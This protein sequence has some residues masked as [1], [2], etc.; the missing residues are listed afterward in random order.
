M[1]STC[2]GRRAGSSNRL[3][4]RASWFRSQSGSASVELVVLVVPIM[5]LALFTVLV[6]RVASVRQEV[7]SAARDAARAA[8]V[9]QHPTA[10]LE[11]AERVA[12][13]ALA[14]RGVSCQTLTVREK[15]LDLRPNG[16][17]ELVVSCEVSFVDLAGLG[18]PGTTTISAQSSAV[19]DRFRGGD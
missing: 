7:T 2:W 6:G 5:L 1:M 10:A 15:H 3:S 8:A 16:R 14:H 17:V 9:R 11:D 19:V 18:L 4:P 12:A 13:S